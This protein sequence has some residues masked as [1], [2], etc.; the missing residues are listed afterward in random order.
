[1]F[2]YRELTD[3]EFIELIDQTQRNLIDAI[4]KEPNTTQAMHYLNRLAYMKK[5]FYNYQ[6]S[7]V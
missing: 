6:G 3:E 2:D 4:E 7:K 5:Q 1:M